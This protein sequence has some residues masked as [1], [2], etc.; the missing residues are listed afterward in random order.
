MASR[1]SMTASSPPAR[2]EPALLGHLDEPVRRFFAH[3][4]ADGAPLAGAVRLTMSGRIRIGAWI[5]FSA[6]QRIDPRSSE[7]RAR[8]GAGPV[9][10]LR[11]VDRYAEGAG[12]MDI[13]LLGRV[14]LA[15]ATGEDVTRSAAGRIALEAATFAPATLLPRTGVRWWAEAEDEI[16]VGWEV[17]PEHPEVRIRIDDTGA[18]RSVSALRWHGKARAYVPC[19]C[20]VHGERR[21]GDIVVPS[22]FTVAWWFGTPRHQPFFRAEIDD[23]AVIA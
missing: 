22:S 13:R 8:V 18:V 1:A 3:A 16:V 19:G 5:P 6:G 12:S 10:L 14:R 20:E 11:V 7:W 4:I 2:F 9:T 21:F 15:H 23:L 17:P